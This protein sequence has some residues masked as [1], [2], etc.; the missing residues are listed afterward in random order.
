MIKLLFAGFV[1][2]LLT[3]M[4]HPI[5]EF[6]VTYRYPSD[7]TVAYWFFGMA[8]GILGA[9]M[10][11][12]FNETDA[13]K[14]LVF[15]LSLPAFLFGFGASIQNGASGDKSSHAPNTEV[16]PNGTVGLLDFFFSSAY[17]QEPS[18][19][20]A[21]QTPS[22][23]R[24]VEINISGQPFSYHVD[25][26][27][28]QGSVVGASF[29]VDQANSELVARPVPDNA[30]SIRI[31]AGGTPL[32]KKLDSKPGQTIEIDLEGTFQRTFSVA[33]VFGKTP[34]LVGTLSAKLVPRP[35]APAGAQGWIF[36]GRFKDG[37]WANVRTIDGIDM[38]KVGDVH[39]ITYSA[40]MRDGPGSSSPQHPT[41]I[42]VFQRVK[43]VAVQAVN[44]ATWAQVQVLP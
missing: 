26:L 22:Y 32:E 9:L 34:D 40:N 7:F 2:G 29:D 15:G 5:Q 41:V 33:Q 23:Q 24:T 10:V 18:P 8:L 37:A 16:H 36:I 1:G 21:S 12:L 17:A 31:T 27:D 14:A 35:K 44:D 3:P 6:F 38:P 11:W 30:A 25:F 4:I 43:I 19:S 20:P 13:R 42:S 39:Q 28:T